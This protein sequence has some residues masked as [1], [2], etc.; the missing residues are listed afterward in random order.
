MVFKVWSAGV[1]GKFLGILQDQNCFY[2][3][4]N[5]IFLLHWVDTNTI[6]GK[7]LAVLPKAVAPNGNGK[8][9]IAADDGGL[10]NISCTIEL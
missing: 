8:Y 10:K 1:S 7:L 9:A 5:I 3:N 2:N 6:M 4:N